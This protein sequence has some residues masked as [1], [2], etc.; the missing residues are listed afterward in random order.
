MDNQAFDKIAY[1]WKVDDKTYNELQKL[2][3]FVGFVASMEECSTG[4]KS[5]AEEIIDILK[6]INEPNK[7]KHFNVCLDLRNFTLYHK[8]EA[9]KGI[10]LRKWE[11]WFEC[12]FFEIEASSFQINK[13][14][15]DPYDGH[16][17]YRAHVVFK[18]AVNF[19]ES[20][21][22]VYIES[23]IDEFVEDALNYKNYVTGTLNDI[24]ID[25]NVW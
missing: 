1:F 17:Y 14:P 22:R 25:I 19:D 16:L 6:A 4:G 12:G 20:F 13:P 18:E 2:I 5:K 8:N 23:D 7:I 10:Y 24:D 9:D 15:M 3:R 21:K 11:V